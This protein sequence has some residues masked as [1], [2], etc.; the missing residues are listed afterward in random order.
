MRSWPAVWVP[1]R[2]PRFAVGGSVWFLGFTICLGIMMAISPIAARYY[3]SGQPEMIGRY[4]RQALWLSAVLGLILFTL[5]QLFVATVL[6]VVGIDSGFRE[7]TVRYVRAIIFGAP[8]ICA[9]LAFRFTTEGIGYT[10][11]IMYTSLFALVC[12]VF[13]NWVFMYGQFGVPAYGAMGCGIASAVTMWLMAIVLAIYVS[14]HSIYKPLKIFARMAPIRGSVLKELL[15]LG[16]PIAITVTAEAGL[17]AAVSVLVG[18]RGANITAAHQIALNFASTMFMIP[19]AL[20]AA[21]TVRIGHALGAA[22]PQAARRRGYV[23]ISMCIAFMACSATFLLLFRDIVVS[24]YTDDSSVIEIAISLLLMAAIFQIAD[25]IQVG[26]AGALRGYKDTRIPMIINMF[27]Y[28]VMGFPLAYLA[29]VTYTGSTILHLGRVRPRAIR[30]CRVAHGEV[31]PSVEANAARRLSAFSVVFFALSDGRHIVAGKV[32]VFSR[33][34]FASENRIAVWEAAILVDNVSVQVCKLRNRLERFL[35]RWLRRRQPVDERLHAISAALLTTRHV[36]AAC[37]KMPAE[38]VSDSCRPVPSRLQRTASVPLCR[39]RMPQV[40]CDRYCD[41][42][43]RARLSAPGDRMVCEPSDQDCRSMPFR[44]RL[45]IPGRSARQTAG[46]R[47]TRCP[48]AHRFAVRL[49]SV[50]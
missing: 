13:L 23:G 5:V 36:A 43:G 37:K 12:N 49:S 7:L 30:G 38:W 50:P 16:T 20:S 25:G 15:T 26:A 2:W 1:S 29:A 48:S 27:S 40:G 22:K 17:F 10:R 4:T 28:W 34:V 47:Q 21:T 3:G 42:T 39:A 18:T 46:P 31:Q 33:C 45:K 44:P 11:P 19:L 24:M 6:D 35:G 32:F 14:R 9:F 8:A 41:E